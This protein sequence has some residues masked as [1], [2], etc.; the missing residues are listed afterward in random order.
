V[1]IYAV[2]GATIEATLFALETGRVG[3]YRVSILNT[4]GSTYFL[5]PTTAGIAEQPASSGLYSWSGTAPT[6]V[7]QYSV[8]WDAGTTS[9]VLATED[10]IVTS[11][12]TQPVP[13]AGNNLTTRAA[14]QAFLEST[15]SSRNDAID[16]AI[17]N[18]SAAITRYCAREFT[19]TAS[20][21]RT[22]A[23]DPGRIRG[24]LGPYLVDLAP[25]DLRTVSTA[26]LHYG[27]AQEI[28]LTSADYLLLPENGTGG[29][30]TELLLRK[31]TDVKAGDRFADFGTVAL[32]IAGAWGFGAIPSDV[33]YACI[34]TVAGWLR[35]DV[36]ALEAGLD[37]PRMVLP[38][39]PMG[40]RIPG[41]ALAL[42]APYRRIPV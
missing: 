25:Y 2:G 9:Q 31:R 34:L 32:R 21:T 39:Q 40:R 17:V 28:T 26:H 7:G 38:D 8:V 10:L 1:S 20:A 5:N 22:I 4:P 36:P 6:T 27:T 33:S 24:P 18:A 16:A 14:V 35:R 13:S 23:V 15:D 37:D 11:S 42:L 29:T 30:Y 41:A 19:A 12:G 3:T